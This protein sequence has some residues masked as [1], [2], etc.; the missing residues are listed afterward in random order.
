M[1]HEN[2]YAMRIALSVDEFYPFYE[3]IVL[4]DN[5]KMDSFIISKKLFNRI[6]AAINEFYEVQKILACIDNGTLNTVVDLV[7]KG[8]LK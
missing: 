6:D 7:K 2:G 1:Q 3:L 5:V 4:K 8:D